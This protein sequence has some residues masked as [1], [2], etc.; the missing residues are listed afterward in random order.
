[1]RLRLNHSGSV[2]SLIIGGG[3]NPWVGGFSVRAALGACSS[4]MVPSKGDLLAGA[5]CGTEVCD[6]ISGM[7]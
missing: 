1:M 5:A 2:T 7:M 4:L 3:I 6:P